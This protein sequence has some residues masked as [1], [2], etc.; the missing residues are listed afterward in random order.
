MQNLQTKLYNV[1]RNT[2]ILY[3]DYLI[4]MACSEVSSVWIDGKERPGDAEFYT[5]VWAEYG[6][7]SSILDDESIGFDD[8]LDPNADSD[9]DSE[10]E[11][12]ECSVIQYY[13]PRMNRT[14]TEF[15]D[16]NS[17]MSLCL[18]QEEIEVLYAQFKEQSVKC[19]YSN[20]DIDRDTLKELIRCILIQRHGNPTSAQVETMLTRVC[21]DF[22][23]SMDSSDPEW[24]PVAAGDVEDELCFGVESN[25]KM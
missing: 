22:Q 7:G 5:A 20:G 21:R 25:L 9:T 24:M 11:S 1:Y 17:S 6:G 18:P 13:S 23:E 10:C 14:I 8:M 19:V 15:V 2:C 3:V 4:S 16:L 12:E